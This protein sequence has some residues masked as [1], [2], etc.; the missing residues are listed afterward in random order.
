MRESEP[1][2]TIVFSNGQPVVEHDGSTR[3]SL[4][5][6]D[7]PTC[8]TVRLTGKRLTIDFSYSGG[9]RERCSEVVAN[10]V[11]VYVG[12]HSGRVMG[13]EL[14]LPRN[15]DQTCLARDITRELVAAVKELG[16]RSG[17]T[18]GMRLNRTAV[19]RDLSLTSGSVPPPWVIDTLRRASERRPISSSP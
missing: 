19:E 16:R 15:E 9:M 7:R 1:I 13:L 4:S 2:E 5:A 17:S 18:V 10:L 8:A 12:E 11:R 14:Q 3:T 6:S